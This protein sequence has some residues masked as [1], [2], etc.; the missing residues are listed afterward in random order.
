MAEQP[1]DLDAGLAH[2]AQK[3][4]GERA[5]APA[6]VGGRRAGLRRIGDERA[7]RLLD[8]GK[9]TA[10][11][12]RAGRIGPRQ[13]LLGQGIV[14]AGIEHQDAH[15]AGALQVGEDVVDARQLIRDVLDTA[16]AGVD[17]QEI[18][19]T[20]ELHAVAAIIK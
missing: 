8:A 18:V 12:E 16:Q 7:G 9:A 6:A 17:R 3:G 15:A 10:G 20:L 11:A 5:V 2:F 14:A 4:G 13:Q 19:R 1:A